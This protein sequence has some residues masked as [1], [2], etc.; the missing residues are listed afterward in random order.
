MRM[1]SDLCN[2][3]HQKSGRAAAPE[4]NGEEI[5]VWRP[6]PFYDFLKRGFDI[7]ASFFAL[8]LLSPVFL[9]VA[10]LVRAEDGQAVFYRQTRLKRGGV[11]FYIFKFRSMKPNADRLEDILTPEQLKEYK[12]YY[13]LADDP[14]LTRIGKKIRKAS[15]DE[16]PQL[17]NI[18][19]GDLSVVGPRPILQEELAQYGEYQAMLLKVKPGLTGYWQAYARCNVSYVN[20]QRQKMDLYYVTHRS[21]WLDC[22]IILRTVLSVLKH[23]G[24]F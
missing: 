22:K 1:Q 4:A 13:W 20:F 12:Q 10:L 24:A 6:K 16:L 14:R 3:P 23:S 7:L 11:P 5:F 15:L 2:T 19:R 8:A 17:V 21:L 9:A 18:L